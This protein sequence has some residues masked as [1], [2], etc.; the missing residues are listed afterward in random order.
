MFACSRSTEALLGHLCS[1]NC[2]RNKFLFRRHRCRWWFI[3]ARI[4]LW[5]R[6]ICVSEVVANIREVFAP[7]IDILGIVI[8]G[9]ELALWLGIFACG[10]VFNLL[11]WLKT[12]SK[13][14]ET[15]QEPVSLHPMPSSTSV[16]RTASGS[17]VVER[18]GWPRVAWDY[19]C[20][21]CGMLE[22]RRWS[23]LQ[24]ENG[25][26]QMGSLAK[27]P[28]P[29][30][31]LDCL[32]ESFYWNFYKNRLG[33]TIQYYSH[34]RNWLEQYTLNNSF[35]DPPPRLRGNKLLSKPH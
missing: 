32:R 24:Y 8:Y 1:S 29:L 4:R 15:S 20:A 23:P 28:E 12:R 21:I 6:V 25:V 22:E 14:L 16:F 3:F 33:N 18:R 5:V 2:A 11:P 27:L 31:Y 13:R 35:L 17:E 34:S 26:K 10:G 30:L 7:T 19:S 9:S